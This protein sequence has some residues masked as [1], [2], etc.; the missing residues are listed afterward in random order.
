MKKIL[1]GYLTKEEIKKWGDKLCN[2]F[3]MP[4]LCIIPYEDSNIKVR[5]TLEEVK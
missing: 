2:A 4:A 5:I 1:I 3:C